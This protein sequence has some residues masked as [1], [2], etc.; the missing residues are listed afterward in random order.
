ML[1]NFQC[2][3]KNTAE[4]GRLPV[5]FRIA[6]KPFLPA[7]QSSQTNGCGV[8]M[9][10]NS[11][12]PRP[13]IAFPLKIN[14]DWYA[15]ISNRKEDKTLFS[16]VPRNRNLESTTESPSIPGTE[17]NLRD[18]RQRKAKEFLPFEAQLDK[19]TQFSNTVRPKLYVQF[20]S[21]ILWR[22]ANLGLGLL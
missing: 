20:P 11:I 5:G 19:V 21:R 10:S 18:L 22:M 7:V 15:R 3:K 2:I 6:Q 13:W 17:I 16:W 14:T 8:L 9:K 4:I 1:T 12:G